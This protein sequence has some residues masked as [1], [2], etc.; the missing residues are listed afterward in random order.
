M[1][2]SE[3]YKRGALEKRRGEYKRSVQLDI[4]KKKGQVM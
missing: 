3:E 2:D 4:E 1:K